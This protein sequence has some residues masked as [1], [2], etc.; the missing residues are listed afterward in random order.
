MSARVWMGAWLRVCVVTWRWEWTRV[1]SLTWKWAYLPF[2][3]LPFPHLEVGQIVDRARKPVNDGEASLGAPLQL[4]REQI[5]E[6]AHRDDL[7]LADAPAN[8]AADLRAAGHLPSD[9][10]VVNGTERYVTVFNA[11]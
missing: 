2:P 4:R 11:V 9:R 10:R 6:H 7:L 1:D 8:L 3:F 5:A